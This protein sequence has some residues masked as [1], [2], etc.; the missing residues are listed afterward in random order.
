MTSAIILAAGL[1]RRMG[2]DKLTLKLGDKML[3]EWVLDAVVNSNIDDI[4]LVLG[5]PSELLSNAI[6]KHPVRVCYNADFK[7]GQGSSIRVGMSYVNKNS[8]RCFFIM[9]DQPFITKD[10]LNAM[11][12]THQNGTIL[13]PFNTKRRGAPVLFDRCFYDALKQIAG[14]DGGKVVIAQ[15]KSLVYDYKIDSDNFFFDIDSK[16]DYDHANNLLKNC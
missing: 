12:K 11:I 6:K 1:S 9:G 10:V 3:I 14:D 13:R 7:T 5:E 16:E 15:N 4:V 8:E 2:K